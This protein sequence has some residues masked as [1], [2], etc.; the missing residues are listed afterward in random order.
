MMK[1]KGFTLIELMISLA[2]GLVISAAAIMLFM[3][4]QKSYSLQQGTTDLQDNANFGLNAIVRDIRLANL[5]N[6]LSVINDRVAFGGIVLTSSANPVMD[7]QT[8]P[9]T[10]LSNL[11]IG[12]VG[13]TVN[14]NLLSRSNGMSIGA[15]PAWTG[16]SN[17]Q[18]SGTNI[19]SDQLTIQYLPQYIRNGA[20]WFGGFDCEGNRIEFADTNPQR[21][22]V[23]RY[24]LR[25]DTNNDP[26]EP[27]RPLALA[28][29]AGWYPI[30]GN[31]TAITNY[32]DAGEIIIKRVDHFRILLGIN[33]G[34]NFRYISVDDYLKLT[35]NPTTDPRP[36]ILSVQFGMLVRSSQTVGNDAMIKD[37]QSFQVL[38]Q[39]VTIKNPNTNS[40]YVR[41]VVSQAIALR[42]TIGE[43]SQ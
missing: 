9:P 13:N 24:F 33:S 25:E 20:N 3:T 22:Y 30:S 2:L 29:D 23:Q 27:N 39:T 12:I 5:N 40:K 37:D 7:S 8:S 26:N 31:P 19:L 35:M 18:I 36:R 15:A 38:D 10:P 14:V 17:A 43:R 28:C 6:S 41:Q 11:P 34:N 42:N 16:A 4:G 1:Q 32:G 21:I